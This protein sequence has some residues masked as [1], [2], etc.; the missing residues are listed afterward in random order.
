M[1]PRPPDLSGLATAGDGRFLAVHDAKN[2][3]EL[4]RPRV[5]VLFTPRDLEGVLYKALTV[6]WGDIDSSDLESIAR[7][8]GSNRYLLCES[9]DDGDPTYR[10]IF[11]ARL[12][13]TNCLSMMLWTGQSQSSTSKQQQLLVSGANFILFTQNATTMHPAHLSTG[14]RLILT[15][16]NLASF[17]QS[18]YPT[19]SREYSAGR[20]WYGY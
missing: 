19:R 20:R 1:R 7:I 8:G 6:D 10:R 11:K 9:G 17:S 14:H 5:S 2:P 4:D 15:S 3:D 16:W 13:D 18:L 12:Q